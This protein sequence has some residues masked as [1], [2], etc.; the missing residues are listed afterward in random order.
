MTDVWP[1][2]LEGGGGDAWPGT[3]ESTGP[4][5]GTMESGF[6]GYLKGASANW[7]DEIYGASKASG[8]PDIIGGFRAPVGAGRLAYEHLTGKQGEA[9]K[10]YQ[11]ARDEIRARETAMQ[12]QHP[13]AFG[14]GELGGAGVSMLGAPEIAPARM[15]AGPLG[16]AGASMAAGAGYGAVSGAGEANTP[17]EML[18]EAAKSAA[19]GTVLGGAGSAAAELAT[20][21]VRKASS[22]YHGLVDPEAEAVRRYARASAADAAGTGERLTP[23][24]I[25]LAQRV[26][27]SVAPIDTSGQAVRE[28]GRTASNFSPEAQ[29]ALKEFTQNRFEEQSPRIAG[30]IRQITGGA[31][32]AADLEALQ[33]AAKKTNRPAYKAAYAAGE[34]GLWTPEL[35]RLASSPAVRQAMQNAVQRGRD[36]AVA[37]GMGAF[38]PGVTFENGIMQFGRGKGAPPYPNMQYWDYVQRELRDMQNAAKRT[39]RN[40]EAGA[41]GTLHR[42]LLSELDNANPTFGTARQGA[43]AYF[44]AE[45]ALEAGQTF[46]KSGADIA[47]A[48]QALKRMSAPERELFARGYASRLADTVERIGDNRNVLI[49]QAFNSTAGKQRTQLAMGP[50]RAQQ[51]EA[52]LRVEGLVDQ[53]RKVLGNS[54]TARQMIAAAAFGAGGDYAVEGHFDPTHMVGAALAGASFPHAYQQIGQLVSRRVATQLGKL[55]TSQNPVDLARGAKIA[56]REAAVMRRLR[57]LTAGGVP[58]AGTAAGTELLHQKPGQGFKH[59]G[60]VHKAKAKGRQGGGRTDGGPADTISEDQDEALSRSMTHPKGRATGGRIIGAKTQ[61]EV[62]LAQNATGA[63]FRCGTCKYFKG[64]KCHNGNPELKDRKVKSHWC[65]N[66]YDHAG[67]KVIA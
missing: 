55:L 15:L 4:S 41:L 2:T 18:P 54:T 19:V 24:D 38:N 32:A 66:L 65:C 58:S 22:L 46:V 8:L 12:Q 67:M 64:G 42:S 33:G 13:T 59:G 51:L 23:Q 28:L 21:L 26:G 62:G 14:A 30:F 53:S 5:Y 49:N 17:Q 63:T 36:R 9:T 16:R 60:K 45:N 31:D 11:R 37:E 61:S 1:G 39:G 48:R 57:Q 6:E 44:G 25:A 3:P 7:R 52:L 20:P 10:E 27:M 34:G 56:S 47:G 50:G 40:E 29:E 35:E 43:A